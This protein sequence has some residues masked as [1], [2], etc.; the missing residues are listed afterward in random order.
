MP[1]KTFKH[2]RFKPH[3][4]HGNGVQAV[5]MFDNGYGAS[6][7]QTTY[8][9]GGKHGFYELA[10]LRAGPRYADDPTDWEIDYAT[11]VTNDV[12]GWLSK[13]SVTAALKAIQALVPPMHQIEED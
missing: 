6:V 3:P 5:V 7:V 2:L 9:Y 11:P 8:S 1:V 12:L 4:N 13:R 10:V